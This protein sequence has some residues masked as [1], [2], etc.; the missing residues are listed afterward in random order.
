MAKADSDIRDPHH[1]SAL[2]VLSPI[3]IGLL[4]LARQWISKFLPHC[5]SKIHRVDYGLIKNE[6]K[7][8]W[9]D[10]EVE[11]AGGN[12]DARKNIVISAARRQLAVPF[13]GKDVPSKSNEFAHPEIVIGLSVLA[14]R[15]D[16]LRDRDMKDLVTAMKKKLF[17]EPGEFKL[18]PTRTTFDNW[19]IS[20]HR[21]N[22]SLLPLELIQVIDPKQLN[23][24]I[25]LLSDNG[26][27]IYYY[28]FSK[29]FKQFNWL[30]QIRS[31]YNSCAAT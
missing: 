28:L 18:R 24:L 20:S 23:T 6:D 31:K 17:H 21:S 7:K 11:N 13:T 22:L 2:R 15:Y 26:E 1:L 14:Y 25:Q 29:N 19:L 8:R 10:E 30:L 16:G 27:A 9:E 4:D 3:G 12:E 5:I